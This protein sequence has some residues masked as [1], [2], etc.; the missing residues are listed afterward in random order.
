MLE[1]TSNLN[2]SKFY[3]KRN[4]NVVSKREDKHQRKKLEKCLIWPLAEQL[5]YFNQRPEQ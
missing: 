3:I 4:F 5:H 1:D 2:S